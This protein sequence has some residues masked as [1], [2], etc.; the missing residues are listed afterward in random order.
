VVKDWEGIMDGMIKA[1]NEEREGSD[2]YFFLIF[3]KCRLLHNELSL[4]KE[5]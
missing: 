2:Y 4:K 3:E 5:S 1:L